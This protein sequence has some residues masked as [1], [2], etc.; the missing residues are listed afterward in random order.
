MLLFCEAWGGYFPQAFQDRKH[1]RKRWRKGPRNE[2]MEVRKALT[3]KLERNSRTVSGG[4]NSTNRNVCVS[5]DYGEAG[6]MPTNFVIQTSDRFRSAAGLA[7]FA[8]PAFHF[9]HTQKP[10]CSKRSRR[11][12]SEHSSHKP[13]KRTVSTLF[14][15]VQTIRL[16]GLSGIILG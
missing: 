13:R 9:I 4:D 8:G 12:C 11:F 1:E 3:S 2:R 16:C 7:H 15:S 5:T 6:R 10:P 14:C